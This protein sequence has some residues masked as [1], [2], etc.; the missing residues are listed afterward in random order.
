VLLTRCWSTDH[1]ARPEMAEIVVILRELI[2]QLSP[3]I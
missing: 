1:T 2:A 3:Q